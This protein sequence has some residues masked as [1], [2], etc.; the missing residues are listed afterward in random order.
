MVGLDEGGGRACERGELL[1]EKRRV[2]EGG[3]HQEEAGLGKT[4]QW[5]LPSGAARVVGVVME[6]V[7]DDVVH[8]GVNGVKFRIS[9]FPAFYAAQG[10]TSLR[11]ASPFSRSAR[12]NS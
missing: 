4:E 8:R 5:D 1:G 3:G 11:M 12:M 10:W 7:H 2:A 6:F 9:T